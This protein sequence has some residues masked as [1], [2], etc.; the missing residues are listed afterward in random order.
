MRKRKGQN[1]EG[2]ATGF[3][4]APTA[5]ARLTPADIQQKE[6]R[7]AF[8]GYNEKD[9]D[10]FLDMVTEHLAAYVEENERLRRGSGNASVGVPTAPS[11]AE[12]SSQAE[13]VL[14]G[15][16]EK[17]AA[18]VR[19]A[20]IKATELGLSRE[21]ES[22]DAHAAITPF[23]QREREFLQSL[24]QL[25]QDHAQNVR[26][27]V[28]RSKEGRAT[29]APA[30]T[31]AVAASESEPAIQESGDPAAV[32]HGDAEGSPGETTTEP[33]FPR[34]ESPGGGM[35]GPGDRPSLRELF[36]GEE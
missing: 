19:E 8:R 9:V 15:A 33:P 3:A 16:R 31:G 2:Q 17:A 14:A 32:T 30:A 7:L 24:G 5:A 10:E 25:V 20:E 26:D 27:M 13:A 6:F 28:R 34:P 21:P 12:S 35:S 11:V 36:W 29:V 22:G 1:Q 18:I 23:L 4:D